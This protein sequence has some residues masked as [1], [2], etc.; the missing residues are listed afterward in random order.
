M[1]DVHWFEYKADHP[2]MQQAEIPKA[3]PVVFPYLD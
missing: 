2:A 1:K 3:L